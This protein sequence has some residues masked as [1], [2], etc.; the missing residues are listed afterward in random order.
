LREGA[1][2][3]RLLPPP[4]AEEKAPP[5]AANPDNDPGA[6]PKQKDTPDE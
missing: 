1:K 4:L 3:E 6:L 2:I 5:N